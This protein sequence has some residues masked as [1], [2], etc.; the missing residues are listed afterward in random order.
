MWKGE[1]KAYVGW[2]LGLP[3][4]ALLLVAVAVCIISSRQHGPDDTPAAQHQSK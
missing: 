2:W 4:I 3:L 1:W